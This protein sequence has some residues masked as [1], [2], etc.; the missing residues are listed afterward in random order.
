[1]KPTSLISSLVAATALLVSLAVCAAADKEPPR[2][3]PAVS[4][5]YDLTV[6][7]LGG[8]PQPL[9]AYKGK[10]VLVVNTASECGYTPQYAGLQKLWD[11]YRDRGLV[12][13]G[14]P[15]N[16]FGGQEPG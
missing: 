11:E 14:F 12:V 6:N 4:S 2:K 8:T 15:S 16:D 1:M 3:E 13:L 5:L 9:S 10:V 7:T